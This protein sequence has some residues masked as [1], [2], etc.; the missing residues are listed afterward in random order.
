MSGDKHA[1]LFGGVNP[2]HAETG[3]T[4]G[5]TAIPEGASFVGVNPHVQQLEGDNGGGTEEGG[6]F[7]M[8]NPRHAGSPGDTRRAY[9][10]ERQRGARRAQQDG[11]TDDTTLSVQHEN[12]S[13]AWRG[14]DRSVEVAIPSRSNPGHE[15]VAEDLLNPMQIARRTRLDERRAQKKL[16]TTANPMRSGGGGSGGEGSGGEGSGG[17]ERT[18]GATRQRSAAKRRSERIKRRKEESRETRS[19]QEE[20]TSESY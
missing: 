9:Y 16:M 19:D 6:A 13:R 17:G 12:P 8:A 10:K 14:A 7:S 11:G 2:Q 4:E 18:D 15:V 3:L 5:L 20:D 1:E